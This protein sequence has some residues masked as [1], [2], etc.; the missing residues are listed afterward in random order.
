MLPHPI[1]TFP[2]STHI[3]YLVGCVLVAKQQTNDSLFPGPPHTQVTK[4][5][6]AWEQGDRPT[7]QQWLCTGR[8]DND[9]RVTVNHACMTIKLCW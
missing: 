3:T 2:Q 5:G 7:N 8:T 4:L 1:I 6:V 9:V